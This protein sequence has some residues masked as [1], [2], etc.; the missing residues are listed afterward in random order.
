MPSCS[1]YQDLSPALAPWG[2]VPRGGF[3]SE[4]PQTHILI[5]NVNS[6]MWAAFSAEQ[7]DAPDPL[8]HWTRQVVE[9]IAEQFNAKALYASEGPPYHPF[10]TWAMQAEAVF[11][12]PIG[13]L[14]HPSFGLWHA[15]R[16][17]LVF[18][19]VIDLPIQDPATSPCEACAEKPCL[20][21]CP[22]EA[23]SSRTYDIPACVGHLETPEGEPCLNKSCA[24][25]RA[26]PVG[27]QYCYV[28]EQSKHHMTAFLR[29]QTSQPKS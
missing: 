26:C 21:T 15:Y 24:A 27:V 8:D 13:P 14:V 28:P 10:Q 2:L 6:A 19:R 16:A 5:G 25:R 3:H 20:S 29:T 18:D 23:F 22:V 7:I 9:P 1:I 4:G 11:P 12:S 17:A